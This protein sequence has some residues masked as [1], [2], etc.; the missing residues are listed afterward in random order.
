[1]VDVNSGCRESGNTP[2]HAAANWGHVE[3][4]M[5]LLA[6]G[7]ADVNAANPKCDYA[8]PLH[9]AVMQGK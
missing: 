5:L 6:K 9:L 8:T 3:M 2:L 7:E 1:M 4:V